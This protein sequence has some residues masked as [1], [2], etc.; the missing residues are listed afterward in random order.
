M[1]GY[2]GGWFTAEGMPAVREYFEFLEGRP[3][4][5]TLFPKLGPFAWLGAA[6][7]CPAFSKALREME[8]CVDGSGRVLGLLEIRPSYRSIRAAFSSSRY[9]FLVVL[10]YCLHIDAHHLASK[11]LDKTID[12]QQA[13]SQLNISLNSRI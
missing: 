2:D 11:V 3:V 4:G 10:S 9:P 5:E 1:V 13:Q 6:V 7:R 12:S 8:L